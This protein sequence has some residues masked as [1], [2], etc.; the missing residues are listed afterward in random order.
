LKV[1]SNISQY[2]VVHADDHLN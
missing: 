1:I 2:A